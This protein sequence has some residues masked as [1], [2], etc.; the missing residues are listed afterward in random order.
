MLD[1]GLYLMNEKELNRIEI[2]KLVQANKL[3]QVDAAEQLGMSDRHFRRIYKEYLEHGPAA[4]ASKKRGKPSNHRLPDGIKKKAL[5]LLKEHYY[6]FGPTFA[7]EKLLDRHNI[8][9][10]VSVI[11]KMMMKHGLWISRKERSKRSYQ[12]R[13]RIACYGELIQ[14]DGSLHHW[15]ENDEEFTLL[16]AVDDATSQIL[17]AHFTQSES[18]LSYFKLLHNYITTNGNPVAFYSD[19]HGVFKVNHKNVDKEANILTQFGRALSELNI[20]II[21]A[22]SP[23]A[24]GKVERTNRILQ[25]RLVKEMRLRN[26]KTIDEANK[27]L[28]EYLVGFNYQ[29]GKLPINS[30]DLHRPLT[31]YE[32]LDQIICWKEDR[33]VS[34]DLTIQYNKILYLIE[35]TK[36]NRTLRRKKVTVYDYHDGHIEIFSKNKALN[37]TVFYD[38]LQKVNSS[39]VVNNK[40]LS[41]VLGYIKEKQEEINEQR[42][43]K[44]PSKVHLGLKVTRNKIKNVKS[45]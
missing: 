39:E 22:N 15:F 23:Q 17:A 18:T 30:K 33:T 41:Q 8:N 20:D 3:S 14:I 40:R 13:Y 44:C 16:L 5:E 38:K 34:N 24:K 32:N 28:P 19:K 36:D 26:I 35:D 10:S 4:L 12:P 37:F 25:D 27:F 31:E 6:D 42:S 9:L 7:A 2:M 43:K 21:C 29:F 1:S 11:R 45:K